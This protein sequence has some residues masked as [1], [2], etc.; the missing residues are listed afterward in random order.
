MKKLFCAVLLCTSFF[1]YA[2]DLRD[3]DEKMV[4]PQDL[5]RR[6]SSEL[7]IRV[8]HTADQSAR[9]SSSPMTRTKRFDHDTDNGAKSPRLDAAPKKI[10]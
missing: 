4:G 8:L 10:D 6:S 9:R 5:I 2:M 3:T 7:R 1:A